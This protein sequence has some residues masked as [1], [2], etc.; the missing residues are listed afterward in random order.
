MT[1]IS[2]VLDCIIKISPELRKRKVGRKMSREDKIEMEGVC[3][4]SLKGAK[5]DVELIDNGHHVTC[6]L[7]GRLMKNSIR[8]LQGDRVTVEISPYDLTKGIITW[9]NR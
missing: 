6:T 4:K 7:A 5:F 3:V 8:V 1:H 9:R 2:I